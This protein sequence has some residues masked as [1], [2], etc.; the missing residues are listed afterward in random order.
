MGVGSRRDAEPESEVRGRFAP[1]ARVDDHRFRT[2]QGGP[3]TRSGG[4]ETF[5]P[6][7]ERGRRG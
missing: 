7:G 6:L 2:G 5:R 3:N 1:L 4:V